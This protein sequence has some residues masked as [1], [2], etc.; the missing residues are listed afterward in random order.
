MKINDYELILGDNKENLNKM[1]NYFKTFM[2]I[3]DKKYVGID[4]EFNRVNNEREDCI[5]SNKFRNSKTKTIFMFYPPDLNEK[6]LK[7]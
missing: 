6:Q 2:K 3:K 1:I 4:F 7:F 5:I